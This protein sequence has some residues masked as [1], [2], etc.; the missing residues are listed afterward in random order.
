MSKWFCEVCGEEITKTNFWTHE[1]DFY[2]D[3]EGYVYD[4]EPE[5]V[6]RFVMGLL[7]E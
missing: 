4:M 5:E 2:I 7:N 6:E 1:H 3:E